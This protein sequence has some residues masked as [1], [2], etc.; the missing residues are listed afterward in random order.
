M[1]LGTE[2]EGASGD[3][4]ELGRGGW[5]GKGLVAGCLDKG[6][7]EFV[8]NNVWEKREAPRNNDGD[9]LD[10]VKSDSSGQ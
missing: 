9:C 3:E 2:G 10:R 7:R 1:V 5:E 4:R 6:P 8:N